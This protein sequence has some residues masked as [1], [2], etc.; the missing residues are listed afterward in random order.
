MNA[1]VRDSPRSQQRDSHARGFGPLLQLKAKDFPEHGFPGKPHIQGTPQRSKPLQPFQDSFGVLLL[2]TEADAGIKHY[3][4]LRQAG[5][6]QP[7]QISF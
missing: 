3:P 6:D 5:L 7:R 4:I 2:L 1:V